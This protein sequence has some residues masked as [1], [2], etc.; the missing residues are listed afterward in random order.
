MC[1]RTESA[2][3]SLEMLD[4]RPIA[5]IVVSS[6]HGKRTFVIFVIRIQVNIGDE[7]VLP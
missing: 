2:L 4:C 3:R 5:R 6:G 7:D 1:R